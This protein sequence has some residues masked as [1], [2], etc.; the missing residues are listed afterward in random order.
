M[1]CKKSFQLLLLLL[2]L[3]SGIF[4]QARENDAENSRKQEFALTKGQTNVEYALWDNLLGGNSEIK[5]QRS[6]TQA[7]PNATYEVVRLSSSTAANTGAGVT[8]QV[9]AAANKTLR[10]LSIGNS[11][12]QDAQQWIY[13]VAVAAGYE[14]VVFA[15]LYWGGCSV[16]QHAKNA[17]EDYAGYEYQLHRSPTQETQNLKSIKFALEQDNWEFITL[18]QVSQDAGMENS[19]NEL[20]E[21]I[22]YVKKYRPNA[23]LGWHMTW[24]YQQNSDH[25]GFANYGRDQMTM[26]NAIVHCTRDIVMKKP[27]MKFV[28]PA[29]T[30]IQ[31]LRT[32]FIGDNLT[33]DGYHMSY[34]LGRYVVSLTWVYKLCEMMGNPFP[35]TITYT[36]NASEVPEYYLPAIREAVKNAVLKPYEVTQSS[37]KN[38]ADLL[39]LDLNN[40][41]RINWE[42]KDNTYWHS[43]GN[44]SQNLGTAPQY[45]T[46]K[47]F[48]RDDLPAGTVIQVDNGFKYRPEGWETNTSTTS[49]RPDEVTVPTVIVSDGWWGKF[50]YRAF[51][52]SKTNGESLVGKANEANDHF[53]I[54]LPKVLG[55]G[56][57]FRILSK[58]S[59]KPLAIENDSRDNN[60]GLVQKENANSAVWTFEYAGNGYYYI[61]NKNSGKALDMP[62]G[63][64]QENTQPIQWDRNNNR[65]QQ[66]N[67]ISLGNNMYRI[68][69]KCAPTMGLDVTG[70][71]KDDNVKVVQ[72]PYGGVA[73]EIWYIEDINSPGGAPIITPYVKG[74]EDWAQTDK[75]TVKLGGD[76]S[77]GPQAN[78]DVTWSWSGPDGFTSEDRQIDFEN[79]SIEKG[80]DYVVTVASKASGRHNKATIH[81]TIDNTPEIFPYLSEGN[82]EW[83][84][85][86]TVTREIGTSVSIGP[87]ANQDGTWSW[88][89]PNGF[90]STEREIT[91]SNLTTNQSGDYTVTFTTRDGKK[92][93]ATFTVTVYDP[94]PAEDTSGIEHASTSKQGNGQTYNLKGQ[95]VQGKKKHDIYI[96]NRKKFIAK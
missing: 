4:T 60:A 34:N 39:N 37:Y 51:N 15:N 47:L 7:A 82:D 61:I 5:V 33:R 21:L 12:S 25:G 70:A 28:F 62:G 46:S 75:L 3:L 52:V 86:Y 89:G 53:R 55:N 16:W 84:E 35:E 45:V 74:E 6:V 73:H 83:K 19:F 10:L 29:G 79:A 9:N 77:I 59:E 23:K 56:G 94:N 30:A 38:I 69:P 36:P 11:F 85:V 76:F 14:D 44:I 8:K 92:A 93:T 78:E 81:V 13:N 22:E 20:D 66:W 67:V 24:A 68:S 42:P 40:Y 17:R 71:S 49:P 31:N 2:C 64:T 43:G 18:Q 88:N 72:W 32:S 58:N 41:V 1:N 26:Y 27:D 80:G 90:T 87:Q 54:Y 91:L 48:T 65:N 50:N 63:S 95:A 96:H 57:D